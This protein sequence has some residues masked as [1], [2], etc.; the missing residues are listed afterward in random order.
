MAR[1]FAVLLNQLWRWPLN[2]NLRSRVVGLVLRRR[3]DELL[4]N[5]FVATCFK[6]RRLAAIKAKPQTQE[7]REE[8]YRCRNRQCRKETSPSSWLDVLRNLQRPRLISQRA[9]N[10]F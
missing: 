9:E 7:N 3:C 4:I 1:R 6:R 8:S 5:L 2:Q 10:L